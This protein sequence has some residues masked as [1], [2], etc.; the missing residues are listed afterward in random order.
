MA[1]DVETVRARVAGHPNWYHRIEL[2]P[3]L[4]TPGAHD[5]NKALSALDRIGLPAS[6]TGL[7]VLDIGCRD[8]YFAFELERRG[9]NVTAI[10][11]A[12]PTLTGFSI[13]ADALGS[14]VDYRVLNVYDLDPERDGL[15]ELVLFLGVLYHVRNPLL[16]LDRV[17]RV[18][19]PGALVFVE[20][21]ICT[22]PGLADRQE[23]FWQFF[24]RGSLRGDPT[25]KW[26]PNVAGL[27]AALEECQLEV[28]E[29]A[30]ENDRAAARAR[31]VYD[32]HL[33]YYRRLDSGTQVRRRGGRPGD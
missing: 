8:G 11:H 15:F 24:P 7:R 22:E 14:R 4:V 19:A 12:E 31:A 26:A 33:D 16:A 28:L 9:A 32:K 1:I 29:V 23:P 18:A 6:C 21:Q 13:A 17:R 27:R 10:D 25:N 20:T 30:A 5:S 3:G 2:M